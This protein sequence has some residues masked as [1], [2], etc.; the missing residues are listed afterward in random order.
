V[1]PLSA[2]SEDALKALARSYADLLCAPDAPA[3]RDVCFSAG[4]RRGHLELRMAATGRT[5]AE[6]TEELEAYLQG[7]RSENF[8]V[9]KTATRTETRPVFVFSGMGPQWWAMG[10]EL[11]RTE[12]VFRQMAETCDE[13]FRSV[14]GWSILDAMTAPENDSRMHETEI[15][16]PANFV[17]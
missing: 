8:A 6:I 12:P 5:S 3:L 13:I 16:Q 11:L 1:L 14:A 7:S 15:A 2:R 9:G 4:A 17:L 10:H